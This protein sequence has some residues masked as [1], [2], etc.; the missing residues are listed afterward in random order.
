MPR[1]YSPGSGLQG[2]KVRRDSVANIFAPDQ[3]MRP[4]MR[5]GKV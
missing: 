4:F 1:S 3:T 2:T 5:R